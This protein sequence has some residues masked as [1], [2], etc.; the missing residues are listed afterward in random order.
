MQLKFTSSIRK[1]RTQTKNIF[2]LEN[3]IIIIQSQ[4]RLHVTLQHLNITH[5]HVK[6]SYLLCF[7]WF[8]EH[9]QL[10]VT[11]QYP[12]T[13]LFMFL[14]PSFVFSI[15]FLQ[16]PDHHFLILRVT[17]ACVVTQ[18]HFCS[19]LCETD[20]LQPAN[21]IFLMVFRIHRFHFIELQI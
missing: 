1:V 3:V 8:V 17:S 21:F 4:I 9:S 16:Y 2:F 12:N 5:F 6:F 15:W 20:S 11:L 19:V 18:T 13:I 7:K 10:R 14:M